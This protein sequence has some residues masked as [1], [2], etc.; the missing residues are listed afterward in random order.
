MPT[1][2]VVTVPGLKLFNPLNGSKAH[3][4]VQRRAVAA[5][6][7]AVKLALSQLGTATRGELRAAPVV[8]VRLTRLGG[9]RMDSN[10]LCAAVK[11]CEDAVAEWLRPGLPAGRADDEARGVRTQYPPGQE[12]GGPFGVRIELT[13]PGG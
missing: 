8:R 6:K 13:T 11:W 1:T 4:A 9:K 12:P 3:W 5:Q 2:V 10:G 7:A